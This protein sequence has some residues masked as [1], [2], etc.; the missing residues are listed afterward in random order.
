MDVLVEQYAD[1]RTLFLSWDAAP[2]HISKTL[3]KHIENHNRVFKGGGRPLVKTAP[4]PAGAQF[5]NVIESIFSGMARAIIH[6][7][8]YK[9]VDDAKAAINQYFAERNAKFLENPRR[10]GKKIWGEERVLPVFSTSNNCK[11]PRYQ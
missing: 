8:N 1:C 11:D 9:S 7:S 4:L 3:K 6:N 2:W 5:L 10:A